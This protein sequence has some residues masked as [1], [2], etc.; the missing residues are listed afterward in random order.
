MKN[1]FRT[2]LVV[3][4]ALSLATA[5]FACDR[6]KTGETAQKAGCSH[7][8]GATAEAGGCPHAAAMKASAKEEGGCHHA[9][10]TEAQ[11][12]ALA[13]GENV[14]LVG[15][16]VCAACDLKTAKSC[17]SMFKAENGQIYAIIGND[18]FEKLATETKH[19]EKK[20][21]IVATSA[22]DGDTAIVQLQSFKILS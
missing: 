16:V 15:Y 8:D 11:R 3:V 13:K 14:T 7:A 1:W 6:E 20:V 2:M 4:A 17:K 18:E 5:V 22:K 21:E 19:G 12:A 9:A 10:A